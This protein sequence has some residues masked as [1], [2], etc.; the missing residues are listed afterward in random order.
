VSGESIGDL[1]PDEYQHIE[2]IDKYE[3]ESG[4]NEEVEEMEQEDKE[5][6][7]KEIDQR[8][9]QQL[10]KSKKIPTAMMEDI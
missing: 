1:N 6:A 5:M 2:E 3:K 9:L 7:D 10:E 4:D 8:R